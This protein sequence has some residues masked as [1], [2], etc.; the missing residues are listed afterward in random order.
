MTELEDLQALIESWGVRHFTARELCTER[1]TGTVTVPPRD[2][3]RNIRPA[4]LVADAVREVMGIPILVVS[5]YR[6][7][8]Y[9]ATVR[10]SLRSEHMQFKALDLRPMNAS[11]AALEQMRVILRG[12]VEHDQRTGNDLD[13]RLLHYDTFVH[14]DS[15]AM[16]D[17]PRGGPRLDFRS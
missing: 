13:A 17:K 12:I 3:W 6:S 1:R 2:M 11:V 7:P 8:D 16:P 15:G 5:G 9:N 4:L 14:I 10:G